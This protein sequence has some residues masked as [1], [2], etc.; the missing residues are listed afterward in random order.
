MC[1][2][3]RQLTTQLNSTE[4]ENRQQLQQRLKTNQRSLF[5]MAFKWVLGTIISGV[6]FISLWKY[7]DWVRVFCRGLNQDKQM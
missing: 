4:Q 5:K 3:D 1:I 2:R 6:T 7:T